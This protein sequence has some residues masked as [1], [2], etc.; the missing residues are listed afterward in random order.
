MKTCCLPL[1]FVLLVCAPCLAA[2]PAEDLQ[3][4]LEETKSNILI[5]EKK[6]D[7]QVADSEKRLSALEKKITELSNKLGTSFGGNTVERRLTDIERRLAK[8]EK[9]MGR[10]AKLEKDLDQLKSRVSKVESRK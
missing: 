8:L 2:E 10:L 9:D 6:L 4:P 7:E 3:N 5:V 1:V